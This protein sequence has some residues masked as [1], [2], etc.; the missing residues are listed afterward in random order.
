MNVDTVK[1]S[2]ATEAASLACRGLNEAEVAAVLCELLGGAFRWAATANGHD[3]WD[4][5]ERALRDV[6][7][8]YP[9]APQ[10]IG[11]FRREH[12]AA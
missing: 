4:A 8:T 9:T 6:A 10:A 12:D 3:F 1:V 5:V 2:H 7:V 11:G